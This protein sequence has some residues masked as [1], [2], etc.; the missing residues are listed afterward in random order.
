MV[1][2]KL[3]LALKGYKE[4]QEPPTPPLTSIFNFFLSFGLYL[5]ISE[6]Y[7]AGFCIWRTGRE[8]RAGAPPC[9][10]ENPTDPPI[11]CLFPIT[12]PRTVHWI[13]S[14]FCST[15]Q[16]TITWSFHL[17]GSW[18]AKCPLQGIY[19]PQHRLADCHT[20]PS[21][22]LLQKPQGPGSLW[23][24]VENPSSSRC[25]ASTFPSCEEPVQTPP[26]I[27]FFLNTF[28]V[29]VF[30]YLLS[31]SS[32]LCGFVPL[33]FPYG[34]FSGFFQKREEINMGN[35]SSLLT[36]IPSGMPVHLMQN[37]PPWPPPHP[38]LGP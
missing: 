8:D 34:Y 12:Q 7:Y 23:A 37:G 4:S 16:R 32:C 35:Q 27:S 2:S 29:L 18:Q 13:W 10:M 9:E 5:Y 21:P 38:P 30:Q 11:L 33:F 14:C 31:Q 6:Y 25:P 3:I 24:H 26:S 28:K 20:E 15:L 22:R 1:K 17:G 19:C 36:R